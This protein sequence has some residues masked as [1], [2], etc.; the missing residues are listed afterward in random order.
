MRRRCPDGF[1]ALLL[2]ACG[3]SSGLGPSDGGAADAGDGG[4]QV[5][6][7]DAVL[8]PDGSFV[9][10]RRGE[11]ALDCARV[12][13]C[14]IDHGGMD[15]ADSDLPAHGV[16]VSEFWIGRTEVTAR[17]FQECVEEGV[18]EPVTLG[19][20]GPADYMTNPAYA[21]RPAVWMGWDQAGLYCAFRGGRLPTEA[22]WE[23]AARGTDER[24][25]PVGDTVSCDQADVGRAPG[26]CE[27]TDDDLPLPVTAR[28]LDVSPYGVRGMTGGVPELVADLW[29]PAYY[30]CGGPP[31]IDPPGPAT[32]PCAPDFIHIARGA[33]FEW[34]LFHQPGDGPEAPPGPAPVTRRMAGD[35]LSGSGYFVGLRC[36]WDNPP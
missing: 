19:L 29:D 16:W 1:A 6:C 10:G 20:A 3:S 28:P 34:P 27:P 25:Y 5:R 26:G 8:I 31:W 32:A 23:K 11:L 15:Y 30:S 9:M 7:D 24:R 18:C 13:G 22:E 12:E 33:G 36:A 21:D 35:D 2:V 17:C 14:A 4:G